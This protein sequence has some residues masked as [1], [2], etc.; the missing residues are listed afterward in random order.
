MKLSQQQAI[1]SSNVSILIQ[2]IFKKDM[3]CTFGDAYRSIEQAELNAARGIGIAN[4]LHCQRLAIDLNIFDRQGNYLSSITPEYKEIG[5]F[6]ESL[7][8][9]NRWGGNFIRKDYNHFEMKQI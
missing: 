9:A 8:N 6:W 5:E 7:N 3:S 1:F 4:S 2:Y